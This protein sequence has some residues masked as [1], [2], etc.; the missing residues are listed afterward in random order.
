MAVTATSERNL[1][2]LAEQS[3]ERWGDYEALLFRD[4]GIAPPS[5]LSGRSGS[6]RASPHT[7]WRPESGWS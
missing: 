6:P 4:A 3:F 5:Y 1:A 2:L 7:A